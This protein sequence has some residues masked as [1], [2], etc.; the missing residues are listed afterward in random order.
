MNKYLSLAATGALAILAIVAV[1]NSYT[2]DLHALTASECAGKPYGTKGCPIKSSSSSSAV[3]ASCGNGYLDENEECDLGFT[4]NGS[5]NCTKECTQLFC[6]DGLISPSIRE[7]CEPEVKETYALDDESGELFIEKEFVEPVCGTSCTI[8]TCNED[9]VCAGG[10]KRKFLPAC[11]N[12]P[13]SSSATQLQSQESSS[14]QTAGAASSAAAAGADCGNGKIDAGE[15]CDD[16]NAI[17]TDACS[18]L[19]K[20]RVCGDGEQQGSEECD[21]GNKVNNDSCTNMCLLPRCGDLVVQA[22]EECDDGNQIPNDNCSTSC[23]FPRCGDAVMQFGEECDDGN[24]SDTDSCTNRCLLPR[25]GDGIVQ[26]AE[27]C[28]DANKISNDA[29]SNICTLPQCGNGVREAG[30]SCD[31]G[32]ENNGDNCT[33]E[34]EKPFCGDGFTQP[35]ESCDD[36][37]QNADDE[38]LNTCRLP[39][40]GD[41]MLHPREQC[42]EG[43]QNSDKRPDTCRSDCRMPRCG[44]GVVD[45]GEQ[46]D[47]GDQCD[48]LCANLKPAASEMEGTLPP[49]APYGVALAG[50]GI[51]SVLAYIF[52]KKLHILVAKTA[53]EN[54]ARSIDDIPLDEIEMPW[55]K[56]N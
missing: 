25:C 38:C 35:G 9:G 21:D 48:A 56:W 30:E 37:N 44:D 28:D 32:N 7:D 10:C 12:V 40:C 19:C 2:P 29:C 14:V 46:C 15:Q 26:E 39:T 23:H 49:Y 41:G 45:A 6:G 54:I 20:A 36:G 34:C 11:T 42:D 17:D 18:N 4:K 5:G 47:G 27:E 55:Q 3:P 33:I 53:G 50:F 51:T 22:G 31:D 13:V 43:F 1:Q 24:R 8:P 16:G 52:R